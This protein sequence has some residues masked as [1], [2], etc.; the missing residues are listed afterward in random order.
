MYVLAC[1]NEFYQLTS[2]PELSWHVLLRKAYSIVAFALVGY[3]LR[4]A[5][6]ENH[7]PR[8]VAPCI[9][10]IAGYSAVIEVGQFLLG[11]HEGFAWN[12]FDTLCGALGGAVAVCDRLLP[13]PRLKPKA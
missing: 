3:L 9:L 5:L 4:R 10:G 8:F 7:R 6:V 2:P 11:S 12:C 1:D 13:V